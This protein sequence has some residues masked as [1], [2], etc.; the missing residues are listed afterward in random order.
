MKQ[1]LN[2]QMFCIRNYKYAFLR[3][4]CVVIFEV[5]ANQGDGSKYIFK[6]LDSIDSV[7]VT[8]SQWNIFSKIDKFNRI[9]F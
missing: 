9:L 1:K 4:L 8:E 3:F 5:L 6:N 2:N 7:F